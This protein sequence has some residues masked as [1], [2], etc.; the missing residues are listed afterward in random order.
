MR[1]VLPALLAL[2]CL[3]AGTL[4]APPPS[5]RSRRARQAAD[6]GGEDA[7][8]ISLHGWSETGFRCRR[9]A[10]GG[11]SNSRLNARLNADSD[12]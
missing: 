10:A 5:S 11:M 8:G 1:D 2:A 9:Q 12:S 4:S 6:V 7:L 3:A